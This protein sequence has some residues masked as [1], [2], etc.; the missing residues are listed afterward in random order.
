MRKLHCYI[1]GR[2]ITRRLH[3]GR[4]HVLFR[5]LFRSQGALASPKGGRS[6]SRSRGSV[7]A[8]P[9]SVGL[10]GRVGRVITLG[11]GPDPVNSVSCEVLGAAGDGDQ[12]R[13]VEQV[14]PNRRRVSFVSLASAR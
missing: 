2:C 5:P 8:V 12:P 13:S 11:P 10:A 1:N 7:A 3:S 9:V 6:G 4:P 14:N